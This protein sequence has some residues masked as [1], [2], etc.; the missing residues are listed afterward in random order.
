MWLWNL[1]VVSALATQLDKHTVGYLTWRA[2]THSSMSTTLVRD[3]T[4]SHAAFTMQFGIPHSFFSLS[5]THK[6]EEMELKLRGSVK[7]VHQTARGSFGYFRNAL[8][9]DTNG[10]D[11]RFLWVQWNFCISIATLTEG[12]Q[13]SSVTVVTRI[14]AGQPLNQGSVPG[15]CIHF[16]LPTTQKGCGTYPTSYPV[17][18]GRIRSIFRN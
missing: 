13:A 6:L 14:W 12:G 15:K 7:W 4:T 16:S 8:A 17:H 2:G 3:T 10:E 11:S 1:D 18:P 9:R 5:Y